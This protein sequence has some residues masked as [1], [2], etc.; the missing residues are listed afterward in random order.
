MGTWEMIPKEQACNQICECGKIDD[1]S[2]MWDFYTLIGL[3]KV[4]FTTL[5][6]QQ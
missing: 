3:G 6:A 2:D 1:P 5:S 4:Y